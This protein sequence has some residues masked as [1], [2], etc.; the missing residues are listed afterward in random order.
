MEKNKYN[1]KK[2]RSK[3]R[4]NEQENKRAEMQHVHVR[5]ERKYLYI[6]IDMTHNIYNRSHVI[7][8]RS[9]RLSVND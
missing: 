6:N 8:L 7:E 2:T 9:G 4:D 3:V 1:T 5:S